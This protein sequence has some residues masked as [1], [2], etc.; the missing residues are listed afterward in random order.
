ME[1]KLKE[2][3]ELLELCEPYLSD[4]SGISTT[5]AVYITPAQ[6]LRERADAIE[7][8]EELKHR[9]NVF[10]GKKEQSKNNTIVFNEDS[11]T[12]AGTTTQVTDGTHS[13]SDITLT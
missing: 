1:D 10:L 7:R 3:I 12:D 4:G 9:I 13:L 8:E 11:L 6:Q 5:Y 2:A